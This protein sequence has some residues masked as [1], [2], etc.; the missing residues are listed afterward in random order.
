[1]FSQQLK[2]MAGPALTLGGLLW[3]T[4]H[5]II[6]IVGLMTGKLAGNIPAAH[7]PLLAHIYFLILPLSYLLLGVGLLGVFARLEG[8]SRRIGITGMLFAS[9]GLVMEVMYVIALIFLTISPASLNGLLG[10][11][12]SVANA[13]NGLFTLLGTGLLGWAA[14]RASVLPRWAAWILIIIAIVTAPILFATPL[15]IGPDWAT[16]TLAF[17]FSG[18]GYTVVG[19][20]LLAVRKHA[21]ENVRGVSIN[22]ATQVK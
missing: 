10:M 13:L 1:M 6:I 9:I 19:T 12:V 22:T 3:I 7:Q 8:R 18:I 4:I 2:R 14:L 5:V 21:G 17:F 20:T 16:D 11:L 15:P